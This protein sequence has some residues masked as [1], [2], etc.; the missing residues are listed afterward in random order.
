MK[1]VCF[2]FSLHQPNQLK[3]YS[4]FDIGDDPFYENDGLNRSFLDEVSSNCYLPM[5][6]ILM[7]N[8]HR[9]GKKFKVCFSISGTLIEQME[10]YRSDVLRS[11]VELAKTGQVEFIGQTYY[12]SLSYIFSPSEFER[13]VKKHM[14][15]TEE[16]F[17]QIPTVFRNTGMIYCN[18][19]AARVEKLRFKGV[20]AEGLDQYLSGRSYNHLYE[21]PNVWH[22]KTLLKNYKLSADITHHFND[23]NWVEYPLTAEKFANWISQE[24]GDF[25]NIFMPYETFG[26]HIKAPSGIFDF[27]LNLPQALISKGITFKTASELVDEMEVKDIYD[28]HEPISWRDSEKDLSAWM[29]N[30]MQTEALHKLYDLEEM[31][32]NSN[33]EQLIHAWSKLQTSDYF[34]YMSTKTFD[35]GATRDYLSPYPSPYECY[36]YFMNALSDLEIKCKKQ[37]VLV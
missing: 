1:N 2:Y 14:T 8:I 27:I 30:T 24:K 29:R 9:L 26:Q 22:I 18:D 34:Y 21:A 4:F 6:A 7:E 15:K 31:V 33:D 35:D 10:M 19:L 36:I 16:V 20:M 12:H 23:P 37:P 13:Q 25:V 3:P 28:I 11:F 5:N 32:I 17:G